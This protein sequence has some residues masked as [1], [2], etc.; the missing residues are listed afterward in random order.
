[1]KTKKVKEIFSC[2]HCGNSSLTKKSI[3]KKYEQ[4][5][6]PLT[7]TVFKREKR[8][9]VS[10][11]YLLKGKRYL[12]APTDYD[13][14]ILKNMEKECLFL[15]IPSNSMMNQPENV[16]KWGDKWRAGTASFTHV[17]HLFLNRSAL[18]AST[19]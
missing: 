13:T 3:A 6:D 2:P 9:P 18:V 15:S 17:N 19:L 16:G 11:S 12:K 7:S 14:T 5:F 10:I 8:T 4:T 1:K